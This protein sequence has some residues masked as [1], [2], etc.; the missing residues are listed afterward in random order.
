MKQD[1]SH[2]LREVLSQGFE[3]RC[4][5][6]DG[7]RYLWHQGCG[8]RVDARAGTTTLLSDPSALP[9]APWFPTTFGLQELEEAESAEHA[10]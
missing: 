5:G 8:L 4:V 9:E 10:S 1:L 6:P 2:T 3:A 7:A